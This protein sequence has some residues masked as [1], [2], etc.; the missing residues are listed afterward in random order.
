MDILKNNTKNEMKCNI[1][2]RLLCEWSYKST[3]VITNIFTSIQSYDFFIT[4]YK[5][6]GDTLQSTSKTLLCILLGICFQ[7]F[8]SSDENNKIDSTGWT[9]Q[10]IVSLLSYQG[11][12]KYFSYIDKYN[13]KAVSK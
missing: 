7:Y 13:I 9:K 11:W 10:S 6:D 12:S 2:L 1:L 8:P 5:D 3:L 4:L